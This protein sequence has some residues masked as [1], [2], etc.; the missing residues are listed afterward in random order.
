MTEREHIWFALCEEF[1]AKVTPQADSDA[2]F[3]WDPPWQPAEVMDP[4]SF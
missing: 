4:M 2:P 1:R 3:E